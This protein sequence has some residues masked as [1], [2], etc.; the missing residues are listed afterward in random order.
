MILEHIL[1]T[2]DCTLVIFETRISP[3][4]IHEWVACIDDVAGWILY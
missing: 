3:V 1:F 2:V 4:V